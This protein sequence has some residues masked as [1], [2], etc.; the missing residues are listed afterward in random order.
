[1]TGPTLDPFLEQEPIPMMPIFTMLILLIHEHG[2]YF[3]LLISSLISFFKDLKFYHTSLFK[4]IFIYLFHAYKQTT[5]AL[6]RHT[7]RGH[8]TTLQMVVSHHVVSGN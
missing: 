5:I 3:H 7:R 1:M 6:F 2:R 4:K 8:Q